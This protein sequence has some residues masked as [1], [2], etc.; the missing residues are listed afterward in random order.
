MSA[1]VFESL[2]KKGTDPFSS[3][4]S[5][6]GV[7]SLNSSAPL[8]KLNLAL[9]LHRRRPGAEGSQV[10]P[11]PGLRV[12]LPGVEPVFAG[13]EFAD[14]ILRP[15]LQKTVVCPKFTAHSFGI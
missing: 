8:K 12:L 4:F 2:A 13:G 10:A 7:P 1:G 14:H 6:D 9:V 11:L 15:P 3:P 5:R